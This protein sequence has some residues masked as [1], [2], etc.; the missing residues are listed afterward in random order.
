MKS[1]HPILVVTIVAVSYVLLVCAENTRSRDQ[2]AAQVERIASELDR[3]TTDAGVY[4]RATPAEIRELDPWGS[5]I[6]VEYAQGGIAETVQVRSAGPDC[7]FY[8]D[9]DIVA[10][11]MAVNFKG[12]GSGIK[13]NIEETAASAARGTVSGAVQGLKQS[14][15]E[16]PPSRRPQHDREGASPAGGSGQ[17]QA[18]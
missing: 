9:D 2:A 11:H 4:V 10:G 13:G 15:R 6:A 8:T 7:R 1:E 3:R 17:G 18:T 12:I 14:I 5:P 16:S